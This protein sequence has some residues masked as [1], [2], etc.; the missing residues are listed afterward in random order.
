MIKKLFQIT[1]LKQN[2]Y[3]QIC[4][5]IFVRLIFNQLFAFFVNWNLFSKHQSSFCPGGSCIYQLLANIHDIFLSFD[6]SSSLETRGV[7]L[8]I[9]KAFNRVQHDGLLFELKHNGVSENLLELIKHFLS[10]RVQRVTLNEKT[11]D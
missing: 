7:F 8:D 11:F 1:D 4:S 10:N 9:S 3:I 6:S 5:K 2:W